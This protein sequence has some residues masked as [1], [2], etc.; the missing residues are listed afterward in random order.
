M[1]LTYAPYASW[2]QYSVIQSFLHYPFKHILECLYFWLKHATKFNN[3]SIYSSLVSLYVQHTCTYL[4]H[5]VLTERLF[6]HSYLGNILFLY[7]LP[8]YIRK[9][10]YYLSCRYCKSQK[11]C[12]TFTGLSNYPGRVHGLYLCT[13]G[14]VIPLMH[15]TTG[16]RCISLTFYI[17]NEDLL[18]FDQMNEYI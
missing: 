3:V 8:T 9:H 18:I 11:Q 7:T 13:W 4:I 17:L 12:L 10:G 5:L 1:F 15:G 14:F 16:T 2:Y 6:F